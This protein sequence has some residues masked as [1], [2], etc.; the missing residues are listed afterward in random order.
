MFQD[1]E[2]QQ[3]YLR[4][5]WAIFK[6]R[7]WLVLLAFVIVVGL[8]VV[9]LVR[10]PRQYEA[11]A[12]V[13]IPTA[14]SGGGLAA[15]LG[16]FLPIGPA[17]DVAT[18]IE[19]IKGRD[20]AEKVVKELKLDKK[21]KNLELDWRQILSG[22]REML[23]VSQRG[24]AN[25]IE[26][27]ATSDSPE[28]ARDIANHVADEYIQLSGTSS[29]KL[30]NDLINQM[31]T[32]LE[33]TRADLEKSR[34]LLLDSEAKAGI[35]S[36]FSLLLIG[37]GASKGEYG[38]QYVVPEVPQAVAELKASIMAMEMRLEM[39]RKNLPE[40]N[41]EVISLKDQ[42]ET[43]RQ[44]LQQE[45]KKAIEKYNKQFGLTKL[46]AEVLFNQQLYSSL[47]SKQEE[48]RAQYIMQNKSPEIAEKALEPLYPSKPKRRLI[49][50]MGAVLG[51]FTG[52]GLS[53][54]L[55]YMDSS[56]HTVE[57]VSR[58][59]G[60]PVLGRI[61]RLR[62]AKNNPRSDA[63]IIYNGVNSSRK[64]WSREFYK[65]SY[66]MLQLE[67][68]AALGGE[69]GEQG[70]GVGATRRVG[71]T[72]PLVPSPPRP[73]V[74]RGLVLLVTSSVPEEGKSIVAANLAISISQTG[75]EVL[76]VDAD[77]RRPAQHALLGMDT[78]VGLTD[79][80]MGKVTWDEVVKRTPI[81]NLSVV[82]SGWKDKKGKE[83]RAKSE[84]QGAKSKE[85]RAKSEEER[86]E[87][88]RLYALSSMLSIDPSAILGSPGLEDFISF[89]RERFDVI[90]FDSPPASLASESLA[91]GSKVNGVV[92]VVKADSTK[93][94]VILQVKEMIQSS[95]GNI[96]GVALNF[97][98]VEKM[99]YKYYYRQ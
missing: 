97:A 34:Q 53:L 94:D 93:K 24:S 14:S 70:N 89:T 45:E 88:S 90:I 75:S 43:S 27:T 29:R 66:R 22:F 21:E 74:P 82:V 62:E 8:T 77:C 71:F 47:V 6:R 95:G 32:K 28:E 91:I 72:R 65:E 63:L 3:S 79:V 36:A 78:T 99:D 44:K 64:T 2:E 54:F 37:G 67:L 68:M 59:I 12:V 83:L 80:L 58:F 1:Q 39:L 16:A 60:L 92:L 33:Q 15:A 26:I 23:K 56:M 25:L 4:N 84:E 31:E 41:P 10:T 19:V 11:T 50:M 30:W 20:I 96:L 61:P 69:A 18:E 13:K 85:Q 17:S 86:A 49:L 9:Y 40:A 87:S 55:E 38:T 7:W 57:D 98:S 76:L 5:Y 35:P 51:V 81:D 46:A 48:L 52:L 42:I 73:L